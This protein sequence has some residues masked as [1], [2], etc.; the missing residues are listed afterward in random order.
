VAA[1]SPTPTPA[2]IGDYVSVVRARLEL[3]QQGFHRLEQ[4]LSILQ[5]APMRMAEDDWRDQLR[6]ILDD[7]SADSADLRS[8]GTRVQTR[9]SLSGDVLKLADDVDFVANEYRMALDFDPTRRT[10]CARAAPRR[11]PPTSS[12]PC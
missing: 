12:I 10:S 6:T 8:L 9:V 11:R 5:K 4:Q 7:L 1:R 3:L 2:L